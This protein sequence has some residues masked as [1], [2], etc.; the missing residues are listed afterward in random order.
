M[1]Q[2]FNYDGYTICVNFTSDN[3]LSITA[4]NNLTHEHFI[5]E[6]V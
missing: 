6:T 4:S 1:T 2:K 3:A 5:N